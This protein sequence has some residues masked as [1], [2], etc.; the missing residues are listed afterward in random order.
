VMTQKSV[1]HAMRSKHNSKSR[2]KLAEQFI[3]Q[4][5]PLLSGLTIED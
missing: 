5:D 2:K 1:A 4:A 3:T